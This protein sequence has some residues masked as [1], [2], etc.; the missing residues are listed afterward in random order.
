M[1][2]I[3]IQE[4]GTGLMQ[5]EAYILQITSDREIDEVDTYTLYKEDMKT[6]LFVVEDTGNELK[7]EKKTKT[8]DYNNAFYLHIILSNVDNL[9]SSYKM[10]KEI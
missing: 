4:T 8:L 5:N 1:T 3:L 10:Y 2:E 7:F 6:V 9:F